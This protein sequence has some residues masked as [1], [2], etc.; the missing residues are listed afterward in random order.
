MKR[1]PEEQRIISIIIV[2]NKGSRLWTMKSS[3]ETSPEHPLK[4]LFMSIQIKRGSYFTKLPQIILM[5]FHGS[6]SKNND[7]RIGQ[8][9]YSH[10]L[11]L[12][13]KNYIFL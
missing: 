4:S 8:I 5:A 6:L 1:I 10:F 2:P 7:L 9:F 13:S 11:R 12:V 3:K